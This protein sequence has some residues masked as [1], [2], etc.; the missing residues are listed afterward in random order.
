MNYLFN[1]KEL[2]IRNFIY[3]Y[4][5]CE[6]DEPRKK[7]DEFLIKNYEKNKDYIKNYFEIILSVNIFN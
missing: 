4:I 5:N 3:D 7:I 2:F 6:A 1:N